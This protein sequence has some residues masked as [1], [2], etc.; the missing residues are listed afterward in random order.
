MKPY[1]TDATLELVHARRHA[2]KAWRK[3]ALSKDPCP[4]SL[5]AHARSI[6][7]GVD[8]LKFQEEREGRAAAEEAFGALWS[9]AWQLLGGLIGAAAGGV[10]IATGIGL[11]IKGHL[12]AVKARGGRDSALM[13]VTLRF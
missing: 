7:H 3:A 11:L 1:I 13:S 4:R 5:A 6:T 12:V 9:W 8:A 2:A 10:G